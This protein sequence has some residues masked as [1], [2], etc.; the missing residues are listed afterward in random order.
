MS[1][2]RKLSLALGIFLLAIIILI[3]VAAFTGVWINPRAKKQD[4]SNNSRTGLD[5]FNKIMKHKKTIIVNK[6]T[7]SMKDEKSYIFFT[8]TLDRSVELYEEFT[9]ES[10]AKLSEPKVGIFIISDIEVKLIFNDEDNNE[11]GS[12]TPSI[13]EEFSEK[14]E[15]EPFLTIDEKIYIYRKE[16]ESSIIYLTTKR[17]INNTTIRFFQK[18]K[19]YQIPQ[20][21]AKIG[22]ETPRRIYVYDDTPFF[23]KGKGATNSFFSIF[24][25]PLLPF[26][27]QILLFLI[28]FFFYNIFYFG[29]KQSNYY[30]KRKSLL[31]HIYAVAHILEKTNS[32]DEAEKLQSNYYKYK[33]IKMK[34]TNDLNKS[35][36]KIIENIYQADKQLN[37]GKNVR[38]RKN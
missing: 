20:A 5:V 14:Y 13:T 12:N 17:N 6:K 28:F 31:Y 32:L 1:W 38:P 3:I 35:S 22:E 11:L 4:L 29:K 18:N 24:K 10:S 21:I 19:E 8:N 37:G 16:L 33:K 26:T 34:T 30:E 15:F 7:P 25:M 27:L 36:E 2:G 23:K 9:E